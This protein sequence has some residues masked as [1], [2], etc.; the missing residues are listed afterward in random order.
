MR[1]KLRERADAEDPA[2][3]FIDWDGYLSYVD[4]AEER[5][6]RVLAEQQ[7]RP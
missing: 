1:R 2:E 7:R 5:F 4:R 3:P 6:R